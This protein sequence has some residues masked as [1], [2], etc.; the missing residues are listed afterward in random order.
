MQGILWDLNTFLM[1]NSTEVSV[2]SI[3]QSLETI[4]KLT[5]VCDIYTCAMKHVC[6][7]YR[8]I[9]LAFRIMQNMLLWILSAYLWTAVSL[10]ASKKAFASDQ[11][12]CIDCGVSIVGDR[13]ITQNIYSASETDPVRLHT[14]SRAEIDNVS[15]VQDRTEDTLMFACGKWWSSLAVKAFVHHAEGLHTFCPCGESV[16]K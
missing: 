3:I 13:T 8:H 7:C 14:D 6:G 15:L 12:L 11:H 10:N 1:F 2:H 4:N 5:F 9:E 16:C